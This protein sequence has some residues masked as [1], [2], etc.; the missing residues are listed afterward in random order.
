[1]VIARKSAAREASRPR[2]SQSRDR[3]YFSLQL[4]LLGNAERIVDPDAEV[5]DGGFEL[6]ARGQ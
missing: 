1:L 5:A 6:I 3:F 2:I 4:D